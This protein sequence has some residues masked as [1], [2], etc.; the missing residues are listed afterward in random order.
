LSLVM[1]APVWFV[2]SHVDIV[3]GNS[4]YQRAF[5]IDQFIRHFGDWWL[6]GSYSSES[7]G[8]DMWDHTNQ[9]VAEGEAGGL[10]SLVCFIAMISVSFGMIGK[11]RKAVGGDKEKEWMLWILGAALFAHIVGYFGISYFDQTRVAWFA[12]LA[13]ISAAA[14][15][16]LASQTVAEMVS[17]AMPFGP[18]FANRSPSLPYPATGRIINPR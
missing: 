11:A 3:G 17:D 12:L 7:W 16:M 18:R 5:L 15:P 2:I 6:L 1:K 8:F 13:M 9:F 4:S 14:G 10:V